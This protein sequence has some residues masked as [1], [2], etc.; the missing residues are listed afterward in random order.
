MPLEEMLQTLV[1]DEYSDWRGYERRERNLRAM[2]EQM[3]TGKAQF[4][5]PGA[6]AKPLSEEP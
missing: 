4:F 1:F 2:Y 6:A 5:V 3:T